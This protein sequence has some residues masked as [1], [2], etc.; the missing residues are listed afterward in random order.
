MRNLSV[1]EIKVPEFV[2]FKKFILSLMCYKNRKMTRVNVN[3][4]AF[5]KKKKYTYL[6]IKQ[7]NY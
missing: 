6:L 5:I 4:F 2:N 7:I 1:L 3:F